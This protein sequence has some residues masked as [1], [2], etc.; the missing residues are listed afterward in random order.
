M[1]RDGEEQEGVYGVYAVWV[2]V[3][4]EEDEDL[5]VGEFQA[6]LGGDVVGVVSDVE[7][8]RRVDLALDA[9]FQEFPKDRHR[10]IRR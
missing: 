6:D 4:V 7:S 10:P 3:Q 9:A 8:A 2:S 5:G 1:A